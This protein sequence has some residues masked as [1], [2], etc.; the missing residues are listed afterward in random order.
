M[1]PKITPSNINPWVGTPAEGSHYTRQQLHA[2]KAERPSWTRFSDLAVTLPVEPAALWQPEPEP[3]VVH[4][5][6][7]AWTKDRSRVLIITPAGWK[8]WAN[9]TA[10]FM[11]HGS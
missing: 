11:A 9:A 4:C 10:E 2:M 8:H 1:L 7:I 5:P 6:I 3:I